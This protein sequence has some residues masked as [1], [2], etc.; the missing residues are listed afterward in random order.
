MPPPPVAKLA[1]KVRKVISKPQPKPLPKATT[2]TKQKL[3]T[4]AAKKATVKAHEE[5]RA[6]RREKAVTPQPQSKE[7]MKFDFFFK[8]TCFRTMTL[9]F[10]TAFKPFFDQCR[11]K[12]KKQPVSEFIHRYANEA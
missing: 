10:K 9:Y 2:S 7:Y 6:N 8:R 3:G 1:S 5:K 4:V 11:S 12:R